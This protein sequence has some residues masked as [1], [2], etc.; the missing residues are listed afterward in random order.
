MRNDE[1]KKEKIITKHERSRSD[2][3]SVVTNN[4]TVTQNGNQGANTQQP[5]HIDLHV[6][7]NDVQGPT[8]HQSVQPSPGTATQS[9][10]GTTQQQSSH[11]DVH[12]SQHTVTQNGSQG[13]NPPKPSG[14]RRENKSSGK[15]IQSWKNV[16]KKNQ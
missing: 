2:D 15:V 8:Y 7:P 3:F 11:Q 10:H 13:S 14:R 6:G 5:S 9:G 16:V 1:K 12:V 4:Q